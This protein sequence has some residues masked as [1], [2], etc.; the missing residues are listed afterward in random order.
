MN[1][2]QGKRSITRSARLALDVSTI[3]LL[4]VS[5]AH[6]TEGVNVLHAANEYAM[7]ARSEGVTNLPS[8]FL[9]LQSV[10][11]ADRLAC[12]SNKTW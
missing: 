10:M 1:Q 3:F 8:I 4:K 6:I 12:N 2:H 11:D 9:H 7:V 5:H